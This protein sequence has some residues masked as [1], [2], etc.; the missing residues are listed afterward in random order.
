MRV[1]SASRSEVRD[2][3]RDSENGTCCSRSLAGLYPED[4]VR[5]SVEE[6][7]L[8]AHRIALVTGK[9]GG[10]GAAVCRALA[11]DSLTIAVADR[12]RVLARALA[13]QLSGNGNRGSLVDVSDERAVRRLYDDIET[14]SRVC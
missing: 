7:L 14:S 3:P 1:T 12:D 4:G 13:D 9:A 5:P 8:Q 11:D 2:T 6:T 10:I